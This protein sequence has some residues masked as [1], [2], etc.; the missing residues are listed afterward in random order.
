VQSSQHIQSNAVSVS[1]QRIDSL[2]LLRGFALL[3]ILLMNVQSFGLPMVAYSNPFAL[4][5]LTSTDRSIWLGL[6]VFADMKFMNLFSMLFG[7]GVLVFGERAI[8]KG[9]DALALHKSRMKWMV[10]FGVIHA[11]LI[12]WGDILFTYAV[13]G[14]LFT[15]LLA[16][17][18][19]RML[20]LASF[21][22]VVGAALL[23]LF[24]FATL[25]LAPQEALDLWQPTQESVKAEIAQQTGPWPTRLVSR[26]EIAFVLQ[27]MLPFFTYWRV[28]ALMLLGV[29]LYRSGFLSAQLST[30][31]YI[32]IGFSCFTTGSA[33]S[34]LGAQLNIQSD[35]NLAYGFVFGLLPNYFGSILTSIGYAAFIML[36][37]K[38]SNLSLVKFALRI[39]H[40]NHAFH[41]VFHNTWEGFSDRAARRG[42]CHCHIYEIVSI[43]LKPI[44]QP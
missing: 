35:F 29:V 5:T 28:T 13:C 18:T 3:G 7:V 36:L 11:Y 4:D 42:E 2:D 39:R 38:S 10:V 9:N 8:Q 21:Y 27:F 32:T 16:L 44:D 43:N 12:W 31:A 26:L 20:L 15:R 24:N 34:V 40:A 1:S 19:K 17:S 41:G 33:I 30:K 14:L 37:A 6:N 22:L 23:A 25:A